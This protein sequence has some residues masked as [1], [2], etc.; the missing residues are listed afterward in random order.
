MTSTTGSSRRGARA[1]GG[2]TPVQPEIL[3]RPVRGGDLAAIV[4]VDAAITGVAKRAYWKR[5]IERT[6]RPRDPD[7]CFLVA[8]TPADRGAAL[9]GFI[10]GEIRAWE[11]GSAPCGWVYVLGV[12]PESRLHGLG[13]RL[14]VALEQEFKRAGVTR[15]RTMVLRDDRLVMQFFRAAGMMAGPYLELEKELD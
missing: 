13:Q 4:A 11:F 2:D 10:A 6:S 7:G 5:L 3:I 15:M 12:R 14:L 8:E 9:L 1:P